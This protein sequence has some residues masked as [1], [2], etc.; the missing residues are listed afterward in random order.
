MPLEGDATERTIRSG[1]LSCEGNDSVGNL[2]VLRLA[3]ATGERLQGVLGV[4]MDGD[5]LGPKVPGVLGCP[6]EGFKARR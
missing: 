5:R 4:G 2:Q 1:E 3:C 6:V